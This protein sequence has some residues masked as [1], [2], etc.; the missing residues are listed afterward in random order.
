MGG[1]LRPETQTEML[2]DHDVYEEDVDH[3]VV[4]EQGLMNYDVENLVEY[5]VENDVD[6][7]ED[8][9]VDC[10][11]DYYVDYD[12]DYDEFEEDMDY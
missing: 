5:N 6:Y 7:D 2:L 4:E 11:V 1:C 10:Y 12:M 3:D 9:Y 8:Y